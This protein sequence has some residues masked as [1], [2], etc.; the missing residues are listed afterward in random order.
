MK[1]TNITVKE[2]TLTDGS[3]VYDVVLTHNDER[4]EF[5]LVDEQQADLFSG[6]LLE[7]LRRHGFIN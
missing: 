3:K 4:I 2:I 1:A 7:V 5:A 6:D